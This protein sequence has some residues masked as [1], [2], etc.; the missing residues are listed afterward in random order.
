MI[1]LRDWVATIPD[2]DKHIAYVGEN[3]A[4]Q[5]QFFLSGDGW[6]AYTDSQFYLDMAFDLSS[7]TTRD[8]RRVVT[9]QK[10]TT[11][12]L[13]EARVTTATTDRQETF[14]V[15]E[16]TVDAPTTT[17][18]AYLTKKTGEEG[19]TLT[20]TV[21]A[22]HTALP[23]KLM[24]TLRA[25]RPD[26]RVK[27]SAL[28]VFEVDP[29]VAATP[30]APIT[31]SVYEQ[32]M[33][34]MGNLCQQGAA[35]HDAALQAAQT[36]TEAMESCAADRRHVEEDTAEAC[37]AADSA[38]NAA[39]AA[40][41]AAQE[42]TAA[43]ATTATQVAVAAQSSQNALQAAGK[44]LYLKDVA[45][46]FDIG[47]NLYD[48]SVAHH[49]YKLILGGIRESADHTTTNYIYS[50]SVG[51]MRYYAFSAQGLTEDVSITVDGYDANYKLVLQHSM[52]TPW[53]FSFDDT[54]PLHQGCVYLRFSFPSHLT[55]VQIEV[56]E[57]ATAYE[58]YRHPRVR[59]AHVETA[60]ALS[61][62]STLPIQAKVVNYCLTTLS[63]QIQ[64]VSD[65]AATAYGR[66]NEAGGLAYEMKQT[67]E[68]TIVPRIV[69]VEAA[70]GDVD[71]AL[72]GIIAIQQSLMGGAV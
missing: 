12:D 17:D 11:E 47:K 54:D 52:F 32:M 68:N 46:C 56:G 33:E 2:A 57:V 25:V 30:A 59:A 31:Q 45:D 49:G 27:K 5:R 58:P 60:D 8:S 62:T 61:A 22:Q 38:L 1:I 7:V 35:H 53:Q 37:D 16:V 40:V 3:G 15:E 42:A 50:P 10:N 71:A 13:S 20:W 41:S 34:E 21:L 18:V 48:P 63:E 4:E 69:A 24:A 70:V 23:G 44:M 9:T 6:Q 29:A 39:T 28:M 51:G 55:D 65:A 36:A 43:A 64:M 14:T 72:D 66:A 19:L 26:G 67:L